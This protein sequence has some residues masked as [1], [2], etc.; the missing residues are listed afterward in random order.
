MDW[1]RKHPTARLI[2]SM[3]ALGVMMWLAIHIDGAIANSGAHSSG[4]FTEAELALSDFE[5]VGLELQADGSLYSTSG[6]PQLILKSSELLVDSV[7]IDIE[8]ASP[9]LV[10]A[11]Y[12]T[13]YGGEY[14]DR[15]QAFPIE[16]GVWWL[17]ARGGYNLR[18][19]L[20]TVVANEITINSIVINGERPLYSFFIPSATEVAL[21]II[22]P[23]LFA[24]AISII[25]KLRRKDVAANG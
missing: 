17:P 21:V 24:A 5:L 3:Y 7:Y 18:I 1:L 8:Y 15:Q 23:A 10:E 22:L 25:A 9:P 2:L 6:D 12:W 4:V 13:S 11:V 14:N 16:Q 19:D 20:G